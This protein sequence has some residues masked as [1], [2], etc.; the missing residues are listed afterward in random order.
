MTGRI[1]AVNK[2]TALA[3]T[4]NTNVQR[5]GDA[6]TNTANDINVNTRS[7]VLSNYFKKSYA[8]TPP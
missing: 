3:K 7:T 8:H 2:S 1:I 5:T 4:V 6:E